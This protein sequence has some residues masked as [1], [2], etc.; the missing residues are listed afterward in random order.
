[1]TQCKVESSVHQ[2]NCG[3][4]GFLNFAHANKQI[5]RQ[6][7][8]VDS[9]ECL[10]ANIKTSFHSRTSWGKRDNNRNTVSRQWL[11]RGKIMGCK[12]NYL[13]K[14]NIGGQIHG[15]CKSTWGC[16]IWRLLE[17]DNHRSYEGYIE[18][19]L[20][21]NE[22]RVVIETQNIPVNEVQEVSGWPKGHCIMPPTA[23]NMR[24][25]I[26]LK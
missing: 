26:L 12:R 17:P 16:F 11:H 9:Q 19:W 22:G 13:Q 3:T 8:Q 7:I 21:V 6:V 25:S 2:S 1:M 23:L 5:W 10:N 24:Y 4:S 14:C 18:S 15:S 20:D